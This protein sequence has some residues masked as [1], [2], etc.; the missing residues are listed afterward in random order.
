MRTDVDLDSLRWAVAGMCV[1]FSR[2]LSP[3]EVFTRYG[4]DGARGARR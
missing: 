3:E 2:D 1:T 4:A